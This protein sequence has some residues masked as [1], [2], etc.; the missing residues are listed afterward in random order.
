MYGQLSRA[1]R[2]QYN[3]IVILYG[4]RKQSRGFGARVNPSGNKHCKRVVK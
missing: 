2:Y 3:I 4:R 1:A